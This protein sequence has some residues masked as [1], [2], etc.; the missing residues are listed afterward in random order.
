MTTYGYARVSTTHQGKDGNSLEAQHEALRSAGATQLYTD[1]FTGTKL[2]RPEFNRLL[3]DIQPGDTL[4]VTKLDRLARSASGGIELVDGLLN[5]GIKVYIL[6]MGMMDSTPTGRLI[7]NVMFAFAEFER[8]MI[9]ERTQEG[10]AIART[11]PD[12]KE[13]RPGL[14]PATI[15]AIRTHAATS[16]RRTSSESGSHPTVK[17]FCKQYGIS[18]SVYYK[19]ASC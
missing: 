5:Q 16:T 17:E 15:A 18:R 14:S 1:T 11:R 13:G 10:K 12:F 8:D 7:R 4:I 3:T 2:D 6:N 9:V 19:Y